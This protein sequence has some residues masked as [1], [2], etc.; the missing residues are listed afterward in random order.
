MVTKREPYR[1]A[2]WFV[3]IVD[4]EQAEWLSSLRVVKAELREVAG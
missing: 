3:M 1:E 4:A 2:R